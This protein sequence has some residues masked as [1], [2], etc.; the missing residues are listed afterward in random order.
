MSKDARVSPEPSLH[1]DNEGGARRTMWLGLAWLA[2]AAASFALHFGSN[3]RSIDTIRDE[4][5]MKVPIDHILQRGWSVETMLDYQEVK[6]PAFYWTY[7]AAGELFGGSM[8][9]MRFTTLLFF[10]A[11]AIPLLL[12]AGRCV[13]AGSSLPAISA[14]YLLIP[15]NLPQGQ[16]LMSE[17]SFILL[18]LIGMWVFVWGFGASAE[19]EHRIAGPVFFAIVLSL[20]LD[21]RPQAVA[22]AGAVALVS[23]ERDGLRSWPWWLACV[24]AG[25]SRLPLW[26][27]WGGLV[28]RG[29]SAS[30]CGLKV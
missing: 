20:A 30:G 27:Y 28:T 10:V 9:D 29:S 8:N 23:L 3:L 6:G 17:I 19:G 2:V 21:H 11:A 18:A 7:A 12:I 24:A 4:H 22:F 5:R 13:R 26:A 25:V 14:F 16:L 15:Y 1:D